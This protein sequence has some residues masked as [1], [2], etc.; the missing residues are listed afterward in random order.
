MSEP[1]APCHKG[2]QVASPVPQ[3]AGKAYMLPSIE[4]TYTTPFAT[5]GDEMMPPLVPP[6]HRGR[7]LAR[8]DA[9]K[10]YRVP[11]DAP[12]YITPFATA[13]EE[14]TA[15]PLTLPFHKGG[16]GFWQDAE[17]AYT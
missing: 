13:G 14:S 8:H 6:C 2:K 7:Q 9:G 1:A 15:L 5:A 3:D 17:K 11:L 16:Q 4:P 12:T 10:A